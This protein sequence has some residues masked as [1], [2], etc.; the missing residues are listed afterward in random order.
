MIPHRPVTMNDTLL[1][2]AT[3]MISTN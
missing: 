1:V 2:T 3:S